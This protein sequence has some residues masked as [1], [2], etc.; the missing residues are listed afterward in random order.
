MEDKSLKI[1][2]ITQYFWPE[3]FR[4][5]EIVEYWKKKN[6]QVDIVTGSPNYPSGKIF[7]NYV[8]N[9]QKYN[10]FL[11]YSIYRVPIILRGSGIKIKLFINYTSFLLSSFIFVFFKLKKKKYDYVF[12]FGTSPVLVGLIGI[13][14]SK[15][16]KI[17]SVI[18]ILDLWPEILYE[19]KI[20]K[21]KFLYNFLKK[22]IFK[23][24]SQTDL[25]FA[26]S[27]TFQK[28]I[29]FSTGIDAYFL[30][31][32]P[33]SLNYRSREKIK[34]IPSKKDFLT[35]IFTGNIG[36]SQNFE[37]IIKAA[38]MLK[39]YKVRWIIVGGG[40]YLEFLKNKVKI[41]NLNNFLLFDQVELSEIPKYI[42]HAD[43]LLATLKGGEVGI[44]TV[45]GKISTYINFKKPI[46]GHLLGE[47]YYLI[48][49]NNL[50]LVSKPGEIDIL[51]KN[52]KKF[53]HLKKK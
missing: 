30:P 7:P 39:N 36:E 2:L 6:F 17:K 26:Q 11:G 24:Y 21:N 47:S 1:L 13:F 9:K 44:A 49:N 5:N 48:K 41:Y 27:I 34:F 22:L 14:F 52:I 40:R 19:L 31:S 45:P 53:L 43:V 38:I 37:E 23:I 8:L 28:K 33:E 4:V 46:L 29:F 51:I 42:N 20:I 10:K 25:V 12:T 3:N 35:I 50:G 15:I 18:W 16:T 32:W